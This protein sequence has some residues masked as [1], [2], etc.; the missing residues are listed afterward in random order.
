[1]DG[2]MGKIREDA[3]A[4]I[5]PGFISEGEEE[6]HSATKQAIDSVK[7]QVEELKKNYKELTDLCQQK[8]DLF[9]V[10]VKFHMT[11]RQVSAS[12]QCTYTMYMYIILWALTCTMYMYIHVNLYCAC[13]KTRPLSCCIPSRGK[14]CFKHFSAIFLQVLFPPISQPRCTCTCR[15]YACACTC[16]CT[17]IHIMCTLLSKLVTPGPAVEPGCL[18]VP[19]HPPS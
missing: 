10:C 5:N 16:I 13:A 2:H 9:I 15:T 17:C 18:G 4:L 7:A 14:V 3:Q 8:R 1:M 11:T 6:M 19:C 12:I